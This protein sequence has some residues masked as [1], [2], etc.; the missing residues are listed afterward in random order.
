MIAIA[1]YWFWVFIFTKFYAKNKANMTENL[2]QLFATITVQREKLQQNMPSTQNMLVKVEP[3]G[4]PASR[5]LSL[6]ELVTSSTTGAGI[7]SRMGAVK[8]YVKSSSTQTILSRKSTASSSY[9]SASQIPN[10]S[11]YVSSTCILLLGNRFTFSFISCSCF[12]RTNSLKNFSIQR[13]KT[14]TTTTNNRTNGIAAQKLFQRIKVSRIFVNFDE[15]IKNFA[16]SF[17]STPSLQ[18][19]FHSWKAKKTKFFWKITIK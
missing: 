2:N 12:H 18:F 11:D 9:G 10:R 15:K 4:R 5:N 17:P 1:W 16:K 19:F 6:S 3:V 7:Q 14:M 13:K 8:A